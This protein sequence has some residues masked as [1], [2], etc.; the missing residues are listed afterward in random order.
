MTVS[1]KQLDQK[2]TIYLILTIVIFV[3]LGARLFYLQ[4]LSTQAFQTRSEENKTRL[5]LL[6][7]R[8]GD[9]LDRNG[10]VLA[11]SKP[12]FSISV[13]DINLVKKEEE[14]QRLVDIIGQPG[15]TVDSIKEKLKNYRRAYEPVEIARL[16]WGKE[17]LGV[18]TRIE[19][20]RQELPGII[21]QENPMRYYPN[22]PVAGH[23][24]GYVG[25][26]DE[27]ELEENIQYNYRINDKI[28]KS[29]VEKVAELQFVNGEKIGLRGKKGYQ[30]VEV[31]VHNFPI[32]ELVTIPPTPGSNVVLTLDLD[33]QKALE[34]ALDQ[35]IAD[36]RKNNQKAGAAAAVIIDPNTGAILALASKPDMNPNDFV[37]GSFEEK[38]SY[39]NDS[40]LKPEFNRAVRGVY[41]PGSTFKLI[42]GIAALEAGAV[43]SDDTVNCTG[44]YW[45]PPYIRCWK[46][47]GTVDFVKAVA[48]SCN[49]YFQN[50][51]HLVGIDRIV[52]VARQ[53]GLGEKTGTPDLLGEQEGLL[54]TPQ[55]KKEISAILINRKYENKRK[56][57]E[58]KYRE[59]FA[60]AQTAE[61]IEKLEKART[62]ELEVLEANYQIEYNFETTWHPF[63]TYNTS[64]GQGS[65]N[66]T[67][68]Q[69]ANY[70]ATIANGGKRFTPY[71]I[72]RIVT[73][74][75]EVL[76]QF[77]P[78]LIN[79]V[80]ISQETMS[81][82]KKGMLAV[83]QPGGTAYS[84][85]KDLPIPVAAKSGTA[86]TGRVGD[87]KNEDFH[88]TFIAF[89]PADNPQLAFAGI[90]E[91]G[92]G[93]AATAGKVAKMVFEHYFGYTTEDNM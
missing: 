15:I 66:Y 91:Y 36:A 87:V 55:W 3:S 14:L 16:P 17:G 23:V 11:T 25:Q 26:I 60:Q 56:Q 59:L 82:V 84:V 75:G 69:L 76:K 38:K 85:F 86:Q 61:E 45:R 71:L 74:E 80:A 2:L 9:I 47:H 93:G 33:L 13:T 88:G 8:R 54:P 34:D 40:I 18:I 21:I 31:N 24:L 64:I 12:V 1:Q 41:P 58:E 53:F 48:Q 44:A 89:A 72:D 39:Y 77:A 63:D 29:G 68:L 7:A 81:L 5:I 42:T 20:M 67:V 65:N 83:T 78:Q 92:G 90:I 70:V 37:D 27:K 35:V 4:V 57:L 10:Q 46:P 51:A 62:A 32:K 49:T 6:P 43:D 79:Q 30:R 73:P 28:G 52:E 50:A 22:G 19:E